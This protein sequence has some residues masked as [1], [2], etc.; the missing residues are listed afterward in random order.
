MRAGLR[1]G[2]LFGIPVYLDV[3]WLILAVWIVLGSIDFGATTSPMGPAL[4]GGVAIV[5]GLLSSLLLHELAHSLVARAEGIDVKSIDVSLFGAWTAMNREPNNPKS[6]FRIA[7]AGP[8][9]NLAL[10]VLL[11]LLL[12]FQVFP[13]GSV[14]AYVARSMAAVNLV[15]ALFNLLPGVPLDGGHA[16]K[17]V[18]WAITG[19][20]Y[21]GMV[22]AARSGQAIGWSC[23]AV[24]LLL[25]FRGAFGGLWLGIIGFFALSSARSYGQ[26]AQL[27]QAISNLQA[28][29]AMQRNFR[30]I[31][32]EM[33]LRDFADRY[34]VI[35]DERE[36]YFAE[37]DGRYKGLVQPER[38]RAIERSQWD[39][40]TLIDI[41]TPMH[42]LDGLAEDAPIERVAVSMER[43]RRHAIPILTPTGAIAG[44]VDKGDIVQSVGHKLGIE[45]APDIVQRIRD[46]NQFPPGFPIANENG[47]SA[48]TSH[49]PD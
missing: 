43:T 24:G 3:S 20:R 49:P 12:G 45:I 40:M 13:A 46:S 2:S 4:A 30:V 25:V 9:A 29:D 35:Q 10:F 42:E 1:L 23:V 8:L 34:L 7:V 44:L 31:D 48:S 33:T 41:V 5:L 47:P 18:V 11:F 38:L 19:D 36:T 15:I 22:W 21:R 26:F 27:R 16:L 28:R 37:A 39:T 14:S 17:A 6:A 32:A